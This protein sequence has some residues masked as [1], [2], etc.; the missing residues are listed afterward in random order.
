MIT[1]I[2]NARTMF[3]LLALFVLSSVGYGFAASNTVSKSGAGDGSETISGYT[4]T[5][6]AYTVDA[7]NPD[8]LDTIT[9]DVAPTTVGAPAAATVKVQLNGA[10]HACT[11][12]AGS[13]TCDFSTAPLDINGTDMD[14][15]QIVATSS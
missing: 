6:I 14:D 12:A 2:L 4:V 9:F 5:N 3:A 8:T 11:I 13:A 1:T 7:T 10:W 15:L